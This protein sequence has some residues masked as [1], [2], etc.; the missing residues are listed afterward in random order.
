M[1]VLARKLATFQRVAHERGVAGVLDLL[2]QKTH[3][4]H[5]PIHRLANSLVSAPSALRARRDWPPPRMLLAYFGGIG[6]D[7]LLT[8]VLRELRRRGVAGT[9][10]MSEHAALYRHN[11]D[12]ERTLIRVTNT[13]GTRAVTM[14]SA[15]NVRVY[16]WDG[17]GWK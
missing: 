4:F 3:W 17:E 2:E 5:H 8:T 16:E 9:W 1:S 10:V 15:G 7:L 13:A 12:P 11:A 6:D 14:T